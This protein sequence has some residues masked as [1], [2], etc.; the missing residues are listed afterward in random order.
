MLLPVAPLPHHPLR[1]DLPGL[2][3]TWLD[4]SAPHD[5]VTKGPASST[6]TAATQSLGLS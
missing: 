1:M 2:V 4:V 3:R 5:V 6:S